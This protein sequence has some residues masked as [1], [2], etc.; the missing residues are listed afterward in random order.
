MG[1]RDAKGLVPQS[2]P[3][4]RQRDLHL[5]KASLNARSNNNLGPKGGLWLLGLSHGARWEERDIG[6]H[7]EAW[8]EAEDRETGYGQE[9]GVGYYFHRQ[10]ESK[11]GSI[12][13]KSYVLQG[14]EK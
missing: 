6:R 13:Y 5:G 9:Q 1:K 8:R 7:E 12:G 3:R 10:W 11:V 2:T 4:Q 14:Q